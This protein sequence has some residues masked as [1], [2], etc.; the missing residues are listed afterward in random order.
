[1]SGFILVLLYVKGPI[2]QIVTAMPLFGQAQASFRKVAEL[3][4]AI[5]QGEPCSLATKSLAMEFTG[6]N[7]ELRDVRYQ[8]P[9]QGT[10]EPFVLGPVNL[11][12][13]AGETLFIIGKNGCGKTT[14][15]KL[16]VGLYAPQQGQLL[17]DGKPIKPSQLDTYRQ[18][19]SVVFFDYYLFDELIATDVLGEVDRYFKK[20]QIVQK[21]TI[22]DGAFSTTDLSTG[23]RK[24]LALIHVFLEDRPVVVLDEWAADQDPTFRRVFY[25]QLLPEMKRHGKTLIVISHDDAYFHVADRVIEMDAGRII[26]R[27]LSVDASLGSSSPSDVDKCGPSSGLS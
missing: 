18:L 10:V 22:R 24:R 23:Q 3:S 25:E 4:A 2:E 14:L 21:V 11:T 15:I 1:V 12:I 16:L 8:F 20:L 17:C 7:I 6:A 19:F 5:T 27:R 13:N 9:A 26:E